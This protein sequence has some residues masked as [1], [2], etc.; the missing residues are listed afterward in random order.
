MD[1]LGN[2]LNIMRRLP[3]TKIEFNLSG[4]INLL[5]ALTDELLQ[6]V[7]Q[8]LA[9]ATDAANGKGICCAITTGMGI[10]TDRLG[11][12]NTSHRSKMVS[13]PRINYESSK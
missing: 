5:P 4:L 7:D 13:N 10:R 2:A 11:Q 8:P 6:R 12:T 1:N 3:P 9:T